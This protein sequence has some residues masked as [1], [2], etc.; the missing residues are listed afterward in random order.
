MK[1]LLLFLLAGVLVIL[2]A[3]GQAIPR[4]PYNGAIVVDATT[5]AVLFEDGADRPGY[6][7]S[8]L[9]LMTLFVVLDRI[10]A[11]ALNLTD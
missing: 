1:K 2:A 9:K 11:D 8:M 10:E 4:D 5:G 6:P 3:Q 7:A